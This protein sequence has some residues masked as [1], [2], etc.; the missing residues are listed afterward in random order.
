[1]KFYHEEDNPDLRSNAFRY[2]TAAKKYKDAKMEFQI[3]A[4]IS[5]HIEIDNC[6]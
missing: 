5:S 2:K 3:T 4:K 6:T 1:M